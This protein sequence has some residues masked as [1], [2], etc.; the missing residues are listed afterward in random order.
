MNNVGDAPCVK[1]GMHIWNIPLI[2]ESRESDGSGG[3]SYKLQPGQEC[4]DCAEPLNWY[5]LPAPK[6][7]VGE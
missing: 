7:E 6:V 5:H 2:L 4:P 3:Y 1:C